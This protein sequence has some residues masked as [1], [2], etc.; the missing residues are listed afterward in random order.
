PYDFIKNI[1]LSDLKLFDK[2]VHRTFNNNDCTYFL[3]SLNNIINKYDSIGDLFLKLMNDENDNV[4]Q[5]ISKFRELFFELPSDISKPTRHLSNPMAN[6]AAKRFNMYLRWM[7]R[8][9]NRGVDFGIWD[10]IKMSSLMCPLDVHSGRISRNLGI[11]TRKQ[12]DW[13]A[14]VELTDNLKIFDPNDPVK[15]DFALFGIGVSNDFQF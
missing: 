7:V 6:S 5:A 13:K 8:K 14:V 9:D 10:K 3:L 2:F 4:C 12:D 15:Y 11:L 1:R